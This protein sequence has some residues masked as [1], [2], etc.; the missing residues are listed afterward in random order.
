MDADDVAEPRRLA[1]QFA[2]MEAN[3]D[4]GIVG[5]SRTLIDEAGRFIA[6]ACSTEG[7]LAIRWKCLL[8]SPF[9]HPTVMLRRSV[10]ERHGLRYREVPRAEDYD[11]WPRLLA[12]TRGANL[13][14]PLLRYRLRERS[15]QSKSDQLAQHDRIALS[16]IRQLVPGFPITLAG[17]DATPRPVRGVQRPRSGDGSWQIRN[18]S[19]SIAGSG[20]R[21]S[22][23]TPGIRK[24][25]R[26]R[27][28][29]SPLSPQP[30]FKPRECACH[31]ERSEGPL[32]HRAVGPDSQQFFRLGTGA[33][34]RRVRFSGRVFSGPGERVR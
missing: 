7:D 21:S 9:A 12:H 17:R 33:I 26:S 19:A 27:G 2:F 32:V 22:L 20:R 15:M 23:H 29:H 31:P 4:V 25:M 1:V 16:A 3:P 18:G 30:P 6:E 8:G 13:P 28:Q 10:L 34:G 14:Q 24:R 5:S 11:L